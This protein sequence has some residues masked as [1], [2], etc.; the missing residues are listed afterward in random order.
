MKIVLPVLIAIIFIA[1][2]AKK[3]ATCNYVDSTTVAPAAE[4]SS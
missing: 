3:D 1:G 2:C 4:I